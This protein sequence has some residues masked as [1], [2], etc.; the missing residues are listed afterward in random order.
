[1]EGAAR[2]RALA[3]FAALYGA[4]RYFDAHEALEAV[5]RRSD[6]LPMRFL[7]GLIQWSVAFEH[8]RRGNAHGALTL[9]DRALSNL[10]DAPPGYLGVDL[11][12]C[13]AAAGDLRRA[14]ADWRAGGPRPEVAA[15]PLSVPGRRP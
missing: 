7:Q 1:M 13:R 3:E 9:L 6:A 12:A 5:W 2:D 15:P 11:A 10:R 4:G 8:H 14:F